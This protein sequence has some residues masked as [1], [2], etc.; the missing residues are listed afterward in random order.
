MV[1]H[2]RQADPDGSRKPYHRR[3]LLADQH[4]EENRGPLLI[5]PD[6][7]IQAFEVLP[8]APHVAESPEL[9]KG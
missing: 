8:V 3:S 7:V 1:R 9:A 2:Q 4:G 5:D 6:G